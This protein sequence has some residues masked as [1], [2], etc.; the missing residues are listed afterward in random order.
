[1]QHD[2]ARIWD[3][4]IALL[5]ATPYWLG[6][7]RAEIGRKWLACMGPYGL[8]LSSYDSVRTNAV[9]IY[10]ALSSRWMPL[11][12]T[13]EQQWPDA[14][15]ETFRLWVNYGCR[16]SAADPI[17]HNEVIPPPEVRPRQMLVR[18]DLLSFSQDELDEYR[19]RVDDAFD[20]ANPDPGAPGQQFFGVHG[21][22]CLHYQEAFLLWHRAYLMQFEQRIGCP[23]PYWN[24][25]AW[26]AAVD[27]ARS[28]GL[29]RAFV[30][31]DYRHPRTGEMRGNPLRFAAAWRGRSKALGDGP[32]PDPV[33]PWVH[34]CEEL[35]SSGD[36]C[37]AKRRAK[38]ALTRKYQEQ[39]QRAFAFPSFSH[40]QGDGHT[41]ANITSFH[42]EPPDSDY[43]Y[44]DVN[45]DGA[46]EQ[47]HDNYH[48]WVGP[49]MADNAYTA[50]DPVFYSYHANIDRI[51]EL[52]F[53]AHPASVFTA[54]TALRPFIG[55]RAERLEFEDRDSFV[56]TTIGDLA[57]DCRGLGYDYAPPVEPDFASAA[58]SPRQDRHG[59]RASSPAET[60]ASG[61]QS[62]PSRLQPDELLVRFEDVQCTFESYAI[63]AFLDFPA[64]TLD[65]V[66]ADNPHY[67][68]RFTRLGM[69]M[70]DDKGR[71]I[72]KGVARILDA[73]PA[74]QRIGVA[75]GAPCRL[76]LLVTRIAQGSAVA[77]EEAS[78]LPG[79]RASLGWYHLGRLVTMLEPLGP[80]GEASGGT[81]CSP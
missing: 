19:M 45:F 68:G 63:D 1:M 69:G 14:A 39:I 3:G 29:P 78:K 9:L 47:P 46:Y 20:V 8:D 36:D 27:G 73:T 23:V 48:G 62:L 76:S 80:P 17:I 25:F 52:W 75:V 13:P 44:R 65:E 40:P 4:D 49:D 56:Y 18:R 30:D 51:F 74:A 32:R 77:D 81:C 54:N 6:E 7:G 50:F 61:A 22:W 5:F 15:L 11:G 53:R 70:E 24:W 43:V 79:F 64:P 26:D 35:Y 58:P 71:C 37:R 31:L 28:A 55:P 66:K 72:T 2:T 42:P 41:W 38:I 34:R 67:V 57:R 21:D 16:R 59:A 10:R 12:A 33:H 60:S